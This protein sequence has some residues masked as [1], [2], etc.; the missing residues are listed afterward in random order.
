MLNV[1]YIYLLSRETRMMVNASIIGI[2]ILYVAGI[3]FG[4]YEYLVN[5]NQGGLGTAIFFGILFLI[6]NC[7]LYCYWDKVEIA[8]AVIKAA[9]DYY[10]ATKRLTFVSLGFFLDHIAF[11]VVITV[12]I[13]Y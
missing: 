4:I 6:F 10:A 13:V 11:I 1:G 12:I 8:V 7:V 9:A 2:N 3:G 5:K